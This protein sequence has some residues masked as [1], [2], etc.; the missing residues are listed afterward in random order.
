M[1]HDDN[2][3][4]PDNNSDSTTPTGFIATN[5]EHEMVTR[6]IKVSF[7]TPTNMHIKQAPLADIHT[8][9]MHAIQAALVDDIIIWNNKGKKAE[10][11][12]VICWTGNPTIHQKQFQIHQKITGGN[13][14]CHTI[15]HYV[16]HCILTSA[17]IASIK[18]I[19]EIHQILRDNSC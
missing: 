5:F 3:D 17:S 2:L 14:P 12:N 7:T 15:R 11:V 9:W 6:V 10:K 1:M 19:P 13:S 16:V 8:H 4:T 18:Q